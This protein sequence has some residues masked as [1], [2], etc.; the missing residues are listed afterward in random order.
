MQQGMGSWAGEDGAQQERVSGL[1]DP[2]LAKARLPQKADDLAWGSGATTTHRK[3]VKGEVDIRDAVERRGAR[4]G[5]GDKQRAARRQRG[6]CRPKDFRDP[7]VVVIMQDP[8]KRD[9]VRVLR[10]RVAEKIPVKNVGPVQKAR[11]RQPLL[12]PERDRGQ[13]EECEPNLRRRGGRRMRTRPPHHRRP[14]GACVV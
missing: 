9:E 10:K 3:E 6:P 1:E 12:R 13:I 14:E 7:G 8:H 11:S 2:R 5:F 4:H